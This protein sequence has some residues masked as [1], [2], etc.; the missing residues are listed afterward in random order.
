MTIMQHSAT[1]HRCV[2][3]QSFVA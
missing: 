3:S 1:S 2:M